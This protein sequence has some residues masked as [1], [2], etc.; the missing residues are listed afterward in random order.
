VAPFAQKLKKCWMTWSF[1]TVQTI[2][3]ETPL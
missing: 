2:N 1:W 3:D